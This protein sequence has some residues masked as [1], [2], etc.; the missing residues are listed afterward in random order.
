MAQRFLCPR[1]HRWQVS[2]D[3]CDVLPAEWI[4]CPLCGDRPGPQGQAPSPPG[5]ALTATQ[6]LGRAADPDAGPRRPWSRGAGLWP[7]M[8]G[9]LVLLLVLPA[10]VWV[11]LAHWRQQAAERQHL[12]EVE[13]ELLEHRA[14]Q[15]QALE[16]AERAVRRAEE[17]LEVRH[18]ELLRS[19]GP[20]R[21][22]ALTPEE[23]AALEKS[24]GGQP[25]DGK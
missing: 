16:A 5:D 2:A 25:K 24:A 21:A 4:V 19:L 11:T 23:Q 14:R 15:Q 20:Q 7:V 10:L 8:L 12:R 13:T 22:P 9:G 1:G 6:R 17:E 18:R 3:G